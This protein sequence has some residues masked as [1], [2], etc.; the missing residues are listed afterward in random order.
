MAEA[1][2]EINGGVVVY[3]FLGP[4][5]GEV[6]VLT[7]GGRFSKDHGGVHELARALAEG[8]KRV[9]L[10]DRPN[11]GR[12]DI[13]LYGRSE[14]HM[15]A[16]TLGLMIKELGIRQVVAAGGSGGARD[17]IIF[18]IMYPELVRKLALWHIVGGVYSQ[19]SLTGVY[20][21][22][23][24]R[25]VRA[26]GIEGVVKMS[27][28]AGSWAELVAANPRNE[29]RLRAV[30]SEEFERVMTRWMDAYVPKP[31]E[32]IPGVSDWEFEEIG[33][34][35]LIVRGGERDFDHPKRTSMEVHCLIRGSRLVEPPWPEDAWEKAAAAAAQGRGSLFDPWV[36]AA[37]MLLDFID[38][39]EA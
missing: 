26:Q 1:E 14:S 36:Q 39:P 11:C 37:P 6:V 21:L 5:D 16:E 4:D 12:S 20:V 24:L 8:G 30:G 32:P 7:P 17:S 25:T 35:T 28:P 31:N 23:E 38:E 2:I 29:D 34:P 13:Q 19:I 9:L 3:E 27:G 10:W 18:T 33:V 22:N 15:R